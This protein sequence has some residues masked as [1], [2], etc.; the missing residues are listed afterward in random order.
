[1]I[2]GFRKSL[3]SWATI[4]LLFLALV[5]IV[6]T[7]FG[8]G[9]F[10]GLG[11]LS[12]GGTNPGD[13][14]A[15]VEGEEI[16]ASEV[17]DLINREYAAARQQQ[18]DLQMS[19]FLAQGVYDQTLN[20]LVSFAAIRHYAGARGLAASEQM[21]DRAI[22]NIPAFRN[23]SGQFDA[24]TFRQV[25]ASQNMSEGWFRNDIR[26]RLLQ[27]QLLAPI[28]LGARVPQ[29][30]AREYANLLYE[31]RQGSVGIVPVQAFAA[32]INPTD[33]ELA[34]F[35]RQSRQAFSEPERRVIRY[36]MIGPQQVAEAGAA[37][38]EEIARVYRANQGRFGPRETRTLQ[39]LVLP[40]RAQAQ[41]AAQQ[42]RG[43]ASF[44][45]V[46]SRLG[47]AAS[48]LTFA[49]QTRDGF[50]RQ[51]PA[52]VAAAAFATAQG[53]V[54]GPVESEGTFHLVRVEA[55]TRIPGRTLESARV[56]IANFIE[57]RKR[58]EALNELV[59]RI[60]DQLADDTPFE[61]IARAERL[62]I[63]TTPSITAAGQAPAGTAWQA[64]PELTP[65]L[66]TAFG[67]DAEDLEPLVE[68]L[69][70]NA[71]FALIEVQRV[72]PAAPPPLS[73]IRDRVR[74]ALIQR[75]ALER[76]QAAAEAIARRVNAGMP[77]A[78]AFAESQP[79]LPAVEGVN[80]RRLEI[81]PNNQRP[82]PA[83]LTL[84]SLPQGR[85]RAVA[86]PNRAG[87]FVV[88]HAQR[89]PGNA[90]SEP[91]AVES[92]R[93]QFA[94]TAGEEIAQQFVRSIELKSDIVRNDDSIRRARNA[95]NGVLE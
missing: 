51:A 36:A 15:T 69:P 45:D 55:I 17:S 34:A 22:A 10:G 33:A 83:L 24:A 14:L 35:Y 53:Q 59:S 87:Y 88:F 70:N 21:V 26:S 89:T 23:F 6:V 78:R 1:M 67:M 63:V 47:F 84:F 27:R 81:A 8:T 40:D 66:G 90:A 46:A 82:S 32:G 20:Q 52:P 42:L 5:A 85:A 4:A 25:L 79:P 37:T 92:V 38:D 41:Q 49:N 95:A 57:Q 11:S 86:A 77:V 56:E 19:D 31:R 62:A 58:V 16:K 80:L 68:T 48:D 44:A 65:L 12:S 64:S 50:A 7:G 43:G 61:Q 71:G 72:D 3:R 94:Q 13:V 91:Q 93:Q 39:H 73:Q 28:A 75:R 30:V 9:G 60:E 29:S 74:A 18:P 76:A 54:A 2:S